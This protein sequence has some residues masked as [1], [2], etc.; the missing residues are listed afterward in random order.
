MKNI[1]RYPKGQPNG[2]AVYDHAGWH[3]IETR[4]MPSAKLACWSMV[5]FFASIGVLVVYVCLH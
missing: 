3:I 1:D 5:A 2:H 4:N